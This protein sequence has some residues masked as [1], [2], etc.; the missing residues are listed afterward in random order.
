MVLIKIPLEVSKEVNRIRYT[1]D[2]CICEIDLRCSEQTD[3]TFLIDERTYLSA[4]DTPEAVK[5]FEQY[6]FKSFQ[7]ITE[8]EID[9]KE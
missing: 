3:G 4:I 8:K 2:G 5:I 1:K 7:R 9:L 6:D